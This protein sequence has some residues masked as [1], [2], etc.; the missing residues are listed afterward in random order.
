[1]A[2]IYVNDKGTW[3]LPK[4]VWVKSGTWRVCKNVFINNRGYWQELIKTVDITSSKSNFNLWEYVGSPTEPISLIVNIASGVEIFSS[5]PTLPQWCPYRCTTTRKNLPK[6]PTAFTV[7]NFPTGST[8]VINNNGYISGGGGFGGAGGNSFA[9]GPNYN[10]QMSGST[11]GAGG[12]GIA[13]G[14][15]NNFDC[16]IVNTGTIAGGGGG[17]GGARA[18][19]RPPQHQWANGFYSAGGNGGDG[20][21]I[22]GYSKTQGGGGGTNSDN[23]VTGTDGGQGGAVGENGQAGQAPL[24]QYSNGAGGQA[25]KAIIANGIEIAVSGNIDGAI[26]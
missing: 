5:G 23:N 20:A 15:N 14:S 26:G 7:G 12:D 8:V 3:K 6:R 9:K 19:Y 4:S 10:N 16:T 11:G 13:K 2:G 24:S 18:Y 25:G 22:T 21:G 1:M 17:G